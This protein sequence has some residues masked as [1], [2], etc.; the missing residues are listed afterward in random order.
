MKRIREEQE[1]CKRFNGTRSEALVWYIS[2]AA[3]GGLCSSNYALS[4]L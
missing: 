2:P 1:R 3:M 4:R